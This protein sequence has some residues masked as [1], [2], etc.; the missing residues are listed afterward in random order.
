[1]EELYGPERLEGQGLDPNQHASGDDAIERLLRSEAGVATTDFVAT[2]RHHADGTGA[3]EAWARRGFVRWERRRGPGGIDF[4]VLETQGENPIERQDATAITTIAEEVAAAGDG[5]KPDNAFIAPAGLTYPSA[6]ERI[7]QLF[8]SPNAPDLIVNPLSYA[9]GRQPGQHGALDVVQSRSPLVFAGPGVRKGATVDAA[10]HHVDIA[11]TIAALMDFPLIDGHDASGRTS[12]ERGKGPDVYLL[13]QDG[14]V[15]EGVADGSAERPERVYLILLDGQSH[16]ELRHRLEQEDGSLPNLRRLV[17]RGAMLRWG[18]ITN[19]P[20]ITWPSHNTIGTG[21]WC[22]HHD[23]VNPSYYL[24]HARE[25]ISPQGRQFDTAQCLGDGVETLFEAFHRVQGEWSGRS[26]AFTASINEPC[27]RGADHA[28]LERRLIGDRPRLIELTKETEHQIDP[29]WKTDLKEQ[30]HRMLGEIDN[31]GLAQARHL[32]L[33]DSHPAPSFVFHEFTATDSAGHD[34]G[35]HHESTRVALDETDV[36]LGHI[37]SLLEEKGLYQ[38][39][40]FVL[41]SDHGMAAADVRLNGNPARIPERSGMAAVTA[42][43]CIYLRDLAVEVEPA[44]DGR[45][46]R[47]TVLDNDADTSG[48]RPPVE[49]AEVI[50]EDASGARLARAATDGDGTCGLALPAD[51]MPGE[52]T[53]IVVAGGFNRRRIRLDGRAAGPDLRETLYR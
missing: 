7:S 53:A 23:I 24:R 15:I 33:D 17:S 3:Y 30:G 31:R 32:F 26:G 52:M 37:F 42:E 29:R 38:S 39:T 20:S 45:T 6:Y 50:V 34:Y 12:S 36:R 4:R 1:M 19:F 5:S 11:P 48:V 51:L 22:G 43:P 10:A 2:Y 40:L 27:T 25:T 35:P 16:S 28:T 18:S 13:R 41:T 49:K 46:A 21:A 47:V 8:D 44:S 9:F 14:S